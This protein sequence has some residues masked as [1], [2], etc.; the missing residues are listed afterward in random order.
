L[1]TSDSKLELN[2][3]AEKIHVHRWPMDSPNWSLSVKEEIDLNLNK[4]KEKKKIR[5]KENII[6]IDNYHFDK[7]K[8]IGITVP[9]FKKETTMIFEGMVM[10]SYAHTHVTTRAKNYLEIFNSLMD[11]KNR[12]FPNS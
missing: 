5:I 8:K 7:I 3:L 4:N 10:D 6:Q 9:F 1:S 12:L 11:W 2:F